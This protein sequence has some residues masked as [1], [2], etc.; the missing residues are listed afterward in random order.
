MNSRIWLYTI[1]DSTINIVVFITAILFCVNFGFAMCLFDISL[2]LCCFES[3][4]MV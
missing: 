4:L 3:P 1:H 2:Q